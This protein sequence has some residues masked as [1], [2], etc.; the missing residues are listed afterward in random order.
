MLL[1]G[2][3]GT[4]NPAAQFPRLARE[5]GAQIIEVNPVPTQLTQAA[6]VVLTGP[7]GAILPQIVQSLQQRQ[8]RDA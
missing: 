7:A 1:V 6:H 5:R 8:S 2:T 3:S 4:V